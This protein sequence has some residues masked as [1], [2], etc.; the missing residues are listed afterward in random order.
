MATKQK[1]RH[2]GP[3][4]AAVHDE[5][6]QHDKHPHTHIYTQRNTHTQ[7]HTHTHT[8]TRTRTNQTGPL[9]QLRY[10]CMLRQLSNIVELYVESDDKN[11][12]RLCEMQFSIHK[13]CA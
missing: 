11:N 13:L 12:P 8:H 9:I 6:A 1:L 4:V 7:T 3:L 5:N 2:F 10:S